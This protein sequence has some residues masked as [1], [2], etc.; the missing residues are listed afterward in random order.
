[1]TGIRP[2]LAYLPNQPV[3]LR[4]RQR[5]TVRRLPP[6]AMP[7]HFRKQH[8][9][10]WRSR[11]EASLN[12]HAQGHTADLFLAAPSRKPQ[13]KGKDSAPNGCS[14]SSAAADPGQIDRLQTASDKFPTSKSGPAALQPSTYAIADIHATATQSSATKS[15]DQS[16]PAHM[17]KWYSCGEQGSTAHH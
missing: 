12:S 17:D 8:M 14:A 2:S 15:S 13:L 5:L 1:M 11:K 16:P 4:A 9:P 7:P 10:P 6:P 3:Q